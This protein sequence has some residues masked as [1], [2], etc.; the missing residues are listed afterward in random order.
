[1]GGFSM[2]GPETV[3]AFS[4]SGSGAGVALLAGVGLSSV[5]S[6]TNADSKKAGSG[7]PVAPSLLV[8]ALSSVGFFRGRR[9]GDCVFAPLEDR[10]RRAGP[11]PEDWGCRVL[12]AAVL[13]FDCSSAIWRSMAPS[14][15]PFIRCVPI[16][17]SIEEIQE[18]NTGEECV[19]RMEA[20]LE[21]IPRVSTR[22]SGRVTA[23]QDGGG[24][25]RDP[26]YL[27]T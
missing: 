3:V 4:F 2:A 12:A 8:P 23:G 17:V 1:M 26:D 6:R 9:A 21:H 15:A 24:V 16:P 20:H 7:S 5:S 25:S 19:M 14:I 27:T 18:W 22:P 10:S 13:C 11:E